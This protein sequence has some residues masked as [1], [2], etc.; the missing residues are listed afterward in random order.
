MARGVQSTAST[1]KTTR[2]IAGFTPSRTNWMSL[3]MIAPAV[4]LVLAL[5]IYPLIYGL[6]LSL[7]PQTG[8]SLFANYT[9]FFTDARERATIW[10][11]L[12]LALPA[13]FINLA[14]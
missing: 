13:T 6:R 10:N 11:T 1:G 14:I 12:R 9:N 2:R 5:F 4:I 7:D 8:G 3:A